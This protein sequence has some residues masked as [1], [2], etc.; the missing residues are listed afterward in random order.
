MNDAPNLWTIDVLIHKRPVIANSSKP[1]KGY[2]KIKTMAHR[3]LENCFLND[4]QGIFIM[5]LHGM[6]CLDI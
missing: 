2:F 3:S 4:A 5:G 6:L 1:T